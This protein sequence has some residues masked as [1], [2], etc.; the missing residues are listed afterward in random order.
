[1][2][3]LGAW[4]LGDGRCEF[5]VFAPL[6]DHLS[7]SLE[8][9]FQRTV[10][11]EREED[12]SFYALVENVHPGDRYFFQ[13]D[14]GQ[15]LPD[16]LSFFQ[17]EDVFGPSC[18]VDHSAFAWHDKEWKGISLDELVMY[19]LHVGTFTEEGTFDGVRSKLSFLKELGVNAIEI[20]PVAQFPGER[21]W[22]Y[23]GVY[24][25]AV[26]HSYGGPDCLK[27]LVDECHANGLSVI[28]DVVYN[29]LGPE[30]NF[31][32]KLMPWWTD[33][34]TT[35]W[36]QA[37]NFD[38]PYSYCLRELC[39][40]N[41]LFW[42]EMFHIDGLRLDAVHGIVDMSA[43]HILKEMAERVADYGGTYHL[44][45]E[46]D[47]NDVRVINSPDKGGYGI[48]AQWNDDFHHCLHTLLTKEASGYYQDF[49][50]LSQLK[51]AI[52]EGF[53][54][55]WKYSKYRKRFHGSSSE[56]I[57]PSKF[58]VFSQ[59]HDQIGN[60]RG[61]ERLSCLASFDALKIAA[62]L[63]L[64]S[65]NLPLLFMGEEYAEESPFLYFMNFHDEALIK[66]IREERRKDG[67][68]DPHDHQTFL[69]SK[70]H[71]E[72]AKEKK[73]RSMLSFY[74]ALLQIRNENRAVA[75]PQQQEVQTIE[76]FLLSITRFYNRQGMY[77]AVNFDETNQH[78]I[79]YLLEGEWKLR[80][81]SSD[82]QW[83]GKGAS[84]PTTLSGNGEL[85]LSPLSFL[86]YERNV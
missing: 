54:Y 17:P 19:E 78:S 39:I 43:K 81:D 55:S 64:L 63:V 10:S 80:F 84:A 57:L 7:L 73:G 23:D 3:R 74:K 1:M 49:G 65:S 53:V 82:R 45:A 66:A 20:M 79:P 11:L 26:Q 25:F 85:C 13:I 71:W 8:S 68:A 69:A 44:I 24:P 22:G 27:K 67:A 50:T 59:N 42:L 47:L 48:H 41:A 38:H 4:F 70:L 29:H 83:Q 40:Q 86:F 75:K 30:G 16:P 5:R 34:Y 28:L 36:G 56:G 2:K 35:P 46:S 32:G 15:K 33:A 12:G 51:T 37:M 58:V 62:G 61:G 6:I 52:E 18:I 31:L 9:P 21:N 72:R 14:E 60:R 76:P 77:M